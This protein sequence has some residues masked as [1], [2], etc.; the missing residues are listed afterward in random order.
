MAKQYNIGDVV[1]TKDNETYVKTENGW[2]LQEEI[3]PQEQVE[4]GDTLGEE[5]KIIGSEIAGSVASQAA[6]AATGPLGYIPVAFSGGVASSI[7]AQKSFG[8][9][10]V[11][12]GR[13]LFNGF[14]TV[15][16]FAP[17]VRNLTAFSKITPTMV[18]QA[19]K[20]EA[21]RGA[22]IGAGYEVATAPEEERELSLS[23]IAEAA[24]IGVV[25]GITLGTL[26]PKLTKTLRKVVGKNEAEVNQALIKGDITKEEAIDLLTIG[27]KVTKEDANEFVEKALKDLPIKQD[28]NTIKDETFGQAK[29][30]ALNSLNK[31]QAKL[32]PSS[33]LKRGVIDESFDLRNFIKADI[34]QGARAEKIITEAINKTPALEQSINK[35]LNTRK[36]DSLLENNPIVKNQL[37]DY[38]NTL[39]KLQR[40]L[41]SQLKEEDFANLSFMDRLKLRNKIYTSIK[42][43][44]Y[45][46]REY[47]IFTNPNFKIDN[48][49]KKAAIKEI[50]TGLKNDKDFN[51]TVTQANKKAEEHVENLIK[52]SAANKEGNPFAPYGV[53]IDG[54]LRHRRNVGEAERKF[55]GEITAP[56]EK[57]RGTLERVAKLT[58][59]NEADIKVSK[60]L[61]DLGLAV[62]NRADDNNFVPLTLKGNLQ[63]DLYVPNYVQDALNLSYL[64]LRNTTDDSF[65]LGLYKT[66]IAL[67]KA[68]K[69][70]L[71]PPSY[72]VNA[73]GAISS[74]LAQG[75]N[76]LSGNF[77]KGLALSF[78]SSFPSK[79]LGKTA[80]QQKLNNKELRDM[81]RYG[82]GTS[83]VITSDIRSGL[84]TSRSGRF[85]SKAISPIGNV[86]AAS[87]N[88]MRYNIWKANQ[89]RFSRIFPNARE[90]EIKTLAARFTNDTFQN[91]EKLSPIVQALSRY[92]V[93]PQFV[94]FTAEFA[95][96]IY[97][98]VRFAKQMV[99]GNFGKEFGMEVNQANITAMRKEG[100]KRLASLVGLVYLGETAREEF[101]LAAGVTPKNEQE[102]K[103]ALPD[104]DKNKALLYSD[105]K[106][107]E[108]GVIK[109]FKYM[110][111]TY[112][113][114]HTM[115]S[116]VINAAQ[117]EKPL[118]DVLDLV[119][120][121]YVGDGTF[122]AVNAYNAI[123]NKD[124]NGRDITNEVTDDKRL[125]DLFSY[126]IDETFTPG[127][128]REKKY[129]DETLRAVKA[130]K[131]PDLEMKDIVL[132][133]VGRR[134]NTV[135][136]EESTG[137][138][139]KQF[140][141]AINNVQGKYSYI[142][143]N[144]NL[145]PDV[146]QKVYNESN[147]VK[148]A[149]MNRI[150]EIN[151]N[152][153]GLGYN[154][155]QRIKILKDAK[156][157]SKDIMAILDNK[158]TPLKKE[159]TITV[160]DIFEEKF[161]GLSRQDF[162][163]EVR[164]LFKNNQRKLAK[165]LIRKY[166]ENQKIKR[167]NITSKEKLFANMSVEDR[168]TYLIENQDLYNDYRKKRLVT[169]AVRLEIKRQLREQND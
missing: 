90:E 56:G 121:H 24:T 22:A 8:D 159:K 129:Y 148:T 125:K 74:S 84:D 140:K 156:V 118:S 21:G 101:N 127:L 141:Q 41:L 96:N 59:R 160:S 7:A 40:K 26:T 112:I 51:Y 169:K 134:V 120:E 1:T 106:K 122:V 117:T 2:F 124:E 70:I 147:R 151:N 4:G 42:D 13:A 45:N 130:G 105:V 107:D 78:K 9:G 49:L 10:E 20:V 99:R 39:E 57:I 93:M 152:L 133:Q 71:N 163:K 36:V 168:A 97:N 66:G 162:Y 44:D 116:D 135:N 153:E 46:T 164:K 34:N 113:I 53:S 14:L 25:G 110:N 115:I 6:G 50:A 68:T 85:V 77:I 131:E 111:M 60:H 28:V 33:V 161:S 38:S 80:A 47:Q 79:S 102:L 89:K 76:P 15:I 132:R 52:Q 63:T 137:F 11:N 61:E 83:N 35:F 123:Q 64:K 54:V 69:V 18:K 126:F 94:A 104:W 98:Q 12:Y 91:Y 58:Y 88:A 139:L 48:K 166:K 165:S 100:V 5:A 155:E 32:I 108:N 109:D 62:R 67:S 136:V 81:E 73:Y 86:Y 23:G 31:L 55:L 138:K 27:G 3:T 119:Y 17:A 150:I 16:P 75:I 95:R 65:L 114:P 154:E 103:D 143:D 146:L 87:D 145:S 144:E 167:L 30:G 72:F 19:A 142:R 128:L 82:L 92:G 29:D 43:G 158:I 157:S 37:T 149:N